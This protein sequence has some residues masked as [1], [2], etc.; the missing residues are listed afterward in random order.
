MLNI[1]MKNLVDLISV[2]SRIQEA[3]LGSEEGMGR[4]LALCRYEEHGGDSQGLPHPDELVADS[5][6]YYF[7]ALIAAGSTLR[8]LQS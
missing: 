5:A 1:P 2:D 6:T 8:G 7:K 3:L 4:A